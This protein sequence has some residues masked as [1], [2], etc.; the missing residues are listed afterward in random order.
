MRGK[1]AKAHEKGSYDIIII[2]KAGEKREKGNSAIKSILMMFIYFE[3]AS[4]SSRS[5][6]GLLRVV[7][8]GALN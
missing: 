4:T 2:K 3:R 8:L 6:D 1:N 5:F 7:V